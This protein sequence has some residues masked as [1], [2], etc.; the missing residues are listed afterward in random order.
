MPKRCGYCSQD[1]V[2]ELRSEFSITTLN[3]IKS[4]SLYVFQ[5]QNI[6]D[7]WNR[8]GERNTLKKNKCN[9]KS[10]TEAS[11]TVSMGTRKYIDRLF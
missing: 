9:R 11:P 8:I 5:F 4:H 10:R 7:H 1:F 2:Y 6:K 3:H